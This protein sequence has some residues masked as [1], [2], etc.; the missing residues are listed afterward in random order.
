MT[1]RETYAQLRERHERELRAWVRDAVRGGKSVT[2]AARDEGV[3]VGTMF[4]L[5][6]RLADDD[7]RARMPKTAKG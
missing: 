6:Q 5:V 2:R 3:N 4:R 1:Y 7:Y